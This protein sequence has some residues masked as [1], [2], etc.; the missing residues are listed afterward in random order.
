MAFENNKSSHEPLRKGDI[1]ELK[2]IK[3]P[4]GVL[5]FEHERCDHDPTI[6]EHWGSQKSLRIFSTARNGMYD[7]SPGDIWKAE[8]AKVSFASRQGKAKE[9]VL[10]IRVC[11]LGKVPS[12][13]KPLSVRDEYSNK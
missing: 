13:G 9:F 7:F 2:I 8:I 4:N 11:P 12:M 5:Y 3:G 10:Y 1:V 6:P